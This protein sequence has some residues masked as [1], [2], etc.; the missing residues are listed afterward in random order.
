MTNTETVHFPP[1]SFAEEEAPDSSAV[2]TEEDPEEGSLYEQPSEEELVGDTDTIEAIH[3]ASDRTP[4]TRE[5]IEKMIRIA[6]RPELISTTA[7]TDNERI[8]VTLHTDPTL[9]DYEKEA[10]YAY[11]YYANEGLLISRV[12]SIY[13]KYVAAAKFKVNRQ[14][15]HDICNSIFGNAVHTY[16][17]FHSSSSKFSYYLTNGQYAFARGSLIVALN[18]AD[19]EAELRAAAPAGEY[20]GLLSGLHV[21]A[22]DGFLEL[23]LGA[24]A[25][26][27][28][29]PAD[30]RYEAYQEG[31]GPEEIS[32][33]IPAD[34]GTS[35]P[36]AGTSHPAGE[37]NKA[38]ENAGRPA[39][40]ADQTDTRSITGKGD[41]K[42]L[43]GDS[44]TNDAAVPMAYSGA[45]EVTMPAAGAGAEGTSE[46]A[47]APAVPVPDIPYEQM[48]VE[49]LQAVILSKMEKNGNVTERMRREV[50]ENI[51]HDSLVNWAN[52][53]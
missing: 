13:D 4:L 38:S 37:A 39:G 43:T 16:D 7:Y 46:D 47:A 26:E 18:N 50:M 53:F 10:L 25:G 17:P 35:R 21:Q 48:S 11:L 6:Y 30:E 15:L 52:S 34:T 20:V 24:N 27:I 2:R 9:T 33:D 12:K 1:G 22:R 29:A 36:A 31:S 28:Y 51:W 23:H 3:A 42:V 19:H 40:K 41:K 5:E 32:G 8:F 44:G 49:K 45:N 14:E